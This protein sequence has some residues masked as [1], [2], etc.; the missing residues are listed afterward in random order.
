MALETS[1]RSNPLW[2]ALRAASR[3]VNR[4]QF[5]GALGVGGAVALL[6]SVAVP[7]AGAAF[8]PGA[9][10]IFE[11][12]TEPINGVFTLPPLPYGYD[13]LEPNIDTETMML[14]HSKHHNTYVTNLNAALAPYADLRAMNITAIVAN[15]GMVPDAIRTAVRNNGGGHLNHSIFWATM[16]PKG[17]GAPT[18]VLGAAINDTFGSFD[19]FKAQFAAAGAGVFGSGWVWLVLNGTKKLQIVTMPN[20]DSPYMMGLTPIVG[21]DVW[22]HAYYLKHRNV[23]ANYLN[24]WWNTVNW[25]SVALRYTTAIG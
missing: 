22:E 5:L 25:E 21:N 23:R 9:L 6:P 7:E 18:G 8:L 16:G 10:P 14:H 13:A 11:A 24:I 2:S 17:G 20:Q 1:T 4:R 12:S 3:N 15:L 19:A